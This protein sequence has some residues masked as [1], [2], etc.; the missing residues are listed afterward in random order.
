M[1]RSLLALAFGTFSLGMSEFVMMGLLPAVA[2]DL[3]VSI[4]QAGHLVSAYA[5]G[6]CAGAPL[7]VLLARRRPL[8]TIL[9][10]LA[11]LIAVGNLCAGISSGYGMLLLMRFVSG[12]PHGAFFGVGSIVAERVADRGRAAQA[13]SIMIAG[14]TVA[15]LLGVPVG[16]AIGD[17][18]SWRAVFLAVGVCGALL[19]WPVHRWIPRIDPLPD[20]GLAGQFRFLRR[21]EPWLIIAATMFGNGAI[22][23]VYSYVSPLMTSAAGFQAG[24]MAWVMVFA[25]LGMTFG[26]L[27]SGRL[28]DRATPE[29]V[30]LG[31]QMVAGA[32]LA[33]MFMLCRHELA[34]LL[35]LFVLTASL[36]ALSSP[37]QLLIIYESKGGEMLGAA[38]IQVAFNTGNALGAC[39]GGL[40]VETGGVEYTSLVGLPLA[41]AGY[42][43]MRIYIGRK[44][45]TGGR[46]EA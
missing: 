23:C 38:M 20:S 34:A 10:A 17:L 11:A 4:P 15:N 26:N 42:A 35:L 12:L 27:L 7:T 45:R 8:K 9:Y 37:E 14:M 43:A 44:D 19:L 13:V 6:V 16:T 40:A 29:R 32:A 21:V 30:A 31:A 33:A 18:V 5:V 24:S 1:K 46:C 41:A 22:F 28:S 39:F 2:S 36:F 3:N 25:G